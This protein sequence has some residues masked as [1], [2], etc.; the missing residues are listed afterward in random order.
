MRNFLLLCCLLSI[1][2]LLSQDEGNPPLRVD[3]NLWQDFTYD[4]G[5]IVGGVGHAYSRPFHWQG[6]QWGHFGAVTAG[7]AGL[8]LVDEDI[9]EWTG[10]FREDIPDFIQD[11]GNEFGRPERNYL[12]TG[13]VYLTGL[14]TKNEKLR[15]TGVLL[16]TSATAAGV[17]Q[18]VTQR[19]VGRARP[20]SGETKDTFDPF[21]LERVFLFE[22]FPSG[23]AI[24]AFSNA[25]AIAKQFRSPWV[26]SAIYTVGLIP[27]F[28]RNIDGF[29]WF[30]DV[31]LSTAVS[32]FIV[33]SIDKYLDKKYQQ[34]YNPETKK[35]VDLSLNFGLNTVGVALR[36]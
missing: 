2:P 24:L 1:S 6:K 29:H 36:F 14:F 34:K 20:I 32:I 12:F 30:S 4:L 7:T 22:S 17:F 21:Q 5:T 3:K 27:G 35:A 16:I 13:G 33:E 25:Y 18:Q 31:A 26:K 10:G 8:F 9:Q 19:I 15:R 23:H 28:I 11:Y